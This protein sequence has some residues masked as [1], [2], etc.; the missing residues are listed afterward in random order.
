MHLL[1]GDDCFIVSHINLI[2][3]FGHVAC[4]YIPWILAKIREKERDRI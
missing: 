1:A 4:G 2:V 3:S